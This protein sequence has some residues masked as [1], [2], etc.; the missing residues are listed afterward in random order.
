VVVCENDLWWVD[1]NGIV[2]FL[3]GSQPNITA[4]IISGIP[5]YYVEPLTTAITPSNL[6]KI[7]SVYH[8][9]RYWAFYDQPN[10]KALCWEFR[11]IGV[12]GSRWTIHTNFYVGASWTT[13]A[14]SDT[15]Q[16]YFLDSASPTLR[17]FPTGYD[18]NGSAI[19]VKYKSRA[20]HWDIPQWDK[21]IANIAP[22]VHDW[23]GTMTTK[24]YTNL[25]GT[26][27]SSSS[28]SY[29]GGAYERQETGQL[30]SAVQGRVHQVELTA[31]TSSNLVISGI[32]YE[33]TKKR[34]AK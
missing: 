8:D 32:E 26:A 25:S 4:T 5:G 11:D 17:Q 33:P 29:T 1:S 22:I 28:L 23:T 6:S 31:S 16:I 15:E 19:A 2:R 13:G 10:G 24:T 7:S 12:P 34:R 27:S 20:Y 30:A 3:S 9:R 14:F 21:G 18:D